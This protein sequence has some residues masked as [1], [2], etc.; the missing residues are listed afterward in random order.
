[1]CGTCETN[2]VKTTDVPNEYHKTR[3]VLLFVS[4]IVPLVFLISLP[5]LSYYGYAH[6]QEQPV[7]ELIDISWFL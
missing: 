6:N 4:G 1:M 7:N 3:M 5:V 2:E